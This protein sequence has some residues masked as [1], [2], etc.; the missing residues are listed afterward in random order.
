[1]FSCDQA[2]NECTCET[3]WTGKLCDMDIDE[4]VEPATNNCP[5]NTTC[6]NTEGSYYCLRTQEKIKTDIKGNHQN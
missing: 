2:T 5:L 1:M 6:I 3:G 4:C